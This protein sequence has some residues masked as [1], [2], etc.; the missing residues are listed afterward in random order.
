MNFH[1][2]Y[3]NSQSFSIDDENFMFLDLD[4]KHT[5][6]PEI[7]KCGANLVSDQKVDFSRKWCGWGGLVQVTF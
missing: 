7:V 3:Q 2:I 1:D 6:V 5:I 4:E